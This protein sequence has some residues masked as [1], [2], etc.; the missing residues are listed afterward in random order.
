MSQL[1]ELIGLEKSG[2]HQTDVKTITTMKQEKSYIVHFH[3]PNFALGLLF[4]CFLELKIR[5]F[6]QKFIKNGTILLEAGGEVSTFL[7]YSAA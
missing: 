5:I 4:S 1:K 2:C 7:D 3:I 6:A